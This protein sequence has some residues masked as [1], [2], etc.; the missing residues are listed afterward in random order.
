MLSYPATLEVQSHIVELQERLFVYVVDK[1]VGTMDGYY[2]NTDEERSSSSSSTPSGF[3][4]SHLWRVRFPR[5]SERVLQVIPKPPQGES[6]LIECALLSDQKYLK[7][8]FRV[9]I[10]ANFSDFLLFTNI[11]LRHS[12]ARQTLYRMLI[13]S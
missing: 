2:I 11:K 9:L 1:E 12:L 10:L 8:P 5:D 4:T 7:V 3:Q 6:R 13:L